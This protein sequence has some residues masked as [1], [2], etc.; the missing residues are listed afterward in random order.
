MTSD[1]EYRVLEIRYA[2]LLRE[3][4]MVEEAGRMPLFRIVHHTR[5]FAFP[6]T[7]TDLCLIRI[8]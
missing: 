1:R 2:G 5:L 7:V 8:P 4:S 6:E 3:W